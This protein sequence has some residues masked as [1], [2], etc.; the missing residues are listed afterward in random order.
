MKKKV[1]LLS[2][3][4]VALLATAQPVTVLS[5][6]KVADGWNPQF[7]A[8]ATELLYVADEADE[9]GL[10][11]AVSDTYV[12]NEDLQLVLYRNGERRVLTPHGSDVNY[13]WQSLS[14]DGTKILFNT[15]YGT[16]VCDLEGKELVNLGGLD[17]PVWF[18]NDKVVGM[19]DTHDGDYF[20]SSCIAIRSLDGSMFQKLTD[21]KEMGM[22]PAVSA[23]TG[24]IAYSTLRGE[25]KL[26][27][28]DLG[29]ARTAPT[30]RQVAP[31][32]RPR[33]APAAKYTKA[34]DVKIYI[35]PG[36]GGHDSDDR[37]MGI[38]P[39]K[40]LDPEGFWESN[41]NLDKGLKLNEW[42]QREGFQTKMSR[43]LNRT[44]DDRALSAIVAEANAY[45]ADYML[46]I[47]SNAGGPSNYVLELYS[48]Q[49]QNDTRVYR[50]P[51]PRQDES[52]AISTVIAKWL[53]KNEVTTWSP[54]SRV[55]GW[56]I[57]DK[58]FGATVMGGWGDGY[59][60]L[61]ALKV[62]GC[63]SEGC[64]H[65]YIPE[66]YRLMNMDYKWREAFYFMAAFCEY[67][68]DYTLPYGA[69][70]GQVRDWYKKI[71]FPKMITIRDSRDQ[72]LPILGAKVTLLQ[73]GKELASY[74]T[75]SLYNGVYFFW[76][77]KPGTYTVRAEAEHYYTMEKEV[78]VVAG[79]IAYQDMLV[80]AKRET[81]P[82]VVSYEPDV[83]LTDSVDVSSNIV[84]NFNW[85]M[86]EEPTREAFSISPE[87]KGTVSFENSYRTLRFKPERM[88]EKGTEYTVTLK[89]SASHPD[90]S[91]PNTM[92]EDFSFSFR[93]KDRP[94]LRMLQSYPA[95]DGVEVPHKPSFI[96][97]FDERLKSTSVKANLSVVDAS[98]NA[99]TINSRSLKYNT[100]GTGYG[101]AS[102]EL[103]DSLQADADYKLIVGPNVQDIVGLYH[104]KTTEIPFHTA[105][106]AGTPAGTLTN[107]MEELA[108]AYDADNSRY[109]DN[110]SAFLN[111]ER[112]YAGSAA[113]ELKYTFG[114]DESVAMYRYT[115][116]L[117]HGNGNCSFGMYVFAD[118]SQNKVEAVWDASGDIKYTPV[119]TLDYAGWRYEEADMSVLPKD[120][121]YQFMGLRIV[122]REGF[123]SAQGSIYADNLYFDRKEAT[124][125]GRLL[126]TD[127]RVWPNPVQTLLTVSGLE[128]PASLVLLSADGK[129]IKSVAGFGMSVA[130]V[131]DGLYL[132]R[133]TTAEG[134]AVNR[135]LIAH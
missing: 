58:T 40:A 50:N 30:P 11:A 59:G 42:L 75:D 4:L 57:G 95:A 92:A 114:D 122:R 127:C 135:V 8:D 54:A 88:L 82:E 76:D 106:A 32:P 28:T 1:S 36:H 62:P 103:V 79:D 107:K 39:F 69:I 67:F 33:K 86:M 113:N 126:G 117:L 91:Y 84:L 17:A 18:G 90:L 68:L 25:V 119:C 13:I 44:E 108:F 14:P 129:E 131:P 93:T 51:A 118:F 64:M 124:G 97:V 121:D 9:V 7:N 60:V 48:G 43:T 132:L 110:A 26:L 20:T 115:G 70:G 55:N 125:F 5:N 63:I 34:G 73:D 74:T 80:N 2:M 53:T 128:R 37:P 41:S 38:Y 56:V 99:Q 89:K 105:P 100:L 61:R 94:S 102:F 120:V 29:S 3:C 27:Q 133:I 22:Y 98:G 45:G 19:L 130:E 24:Q 101:Y 10:Q 12:A 112:K 23:E 116:D 109:V 78:T 81:R 31:R 77:L 85:D 49:D 16:G 52:R 47:H 66:T 111:K 72:L 87:V 104:N 6:R 96:L 65:D 83:E 15:L 46:S 123:L 134:T 71:E 21:P 35:N